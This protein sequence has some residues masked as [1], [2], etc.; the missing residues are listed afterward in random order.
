MEPGDAVR[1]ELPESVAR[2]AEE[3]EKA[4]VQ[5]GFKADEAG[6]LIGEL[7]RTL[8]VAECSS[9]NLI[10]RALGARLS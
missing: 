9:E 8:P 7:V 2:A 5:L 1:A 10:R 4:L 6:R 3:A